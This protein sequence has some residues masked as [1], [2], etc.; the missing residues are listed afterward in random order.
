MKTARATSRHPRLGNAQLDA[1]AELFAVLSEPTRL[2]ILQV[3]QSG[4][5]NVTQI[6]EKSLLKQANVSKQLGILFSAGVVGRERE[7]LQV[8][9]AIRMPLVFDLCKLVCDGLAQEALER[10]K[11][12][13]G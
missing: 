3:L 11:L 2:R 5:A 10:A 7:G 13:R 1:V 4:P 6:V 12:L 9:Y 8:R